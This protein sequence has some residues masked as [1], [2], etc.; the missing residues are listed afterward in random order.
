MGVVEY[1]HEHIRVINIICLCCC[2]YCSKFNNRK[3]FI[4]HGCIDLWIAM[5]RSMEEKNPEILKT[6]KNGALFSGSC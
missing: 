3:D 4:L 2:M 6:A 1:D 5:K